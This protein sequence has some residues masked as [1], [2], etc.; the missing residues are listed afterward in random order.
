M[1]VAGDLADIRNYL[2]D[3]A[4]LRW[5]WSLYVSLGAQLLSLV[6]VLINQAIVLL[7]IGFV[8]LIAPLVVTWL[9][10]WAKEFT[11]KAD[12]CRRLILYADGLG[13]EIPAQ[14]IA[15]VRSWS[16]G[17]QLNAAPFI[18]PYYSS[19]LPSGSTRLVDIAIE[20]AYF[21]RFLAGKAASYLSIIVVIS[22]LVVI[23]IVYFATYT[24]SQTNLL[25]VTVAKAAVSTIAIYL[26]GELLLLW[27]Q[28]LDLNLA[29]DETFRTCASLRNNQSPPLHEAMQVVE[30]YHLALI[31]SP[32][33]PF[34]L[35]RKYLNELNQSYRSSYQLTSNQP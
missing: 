11:Q 31:Q 10:E 29:A 26:L 14:D 20:S 13:N 23:A 12:K 17:V 1:P 27:K 5:W 6:A 32:P 15:T 30:D 9:R 22:V 25:L 35:Y 34:K 19:N 7:I 18:S 3:Q 16:M 24:A 8:V 4:E 2:Y 33:I 21:T 28:Y